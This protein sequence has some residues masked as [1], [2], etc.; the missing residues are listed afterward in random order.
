GFF[1]FGVFKTVKQIFQAPGGL[2]I[3]FF[4]HF[5]PFIGLVD[6]VSIQQS[7]CFP[8]LVVK[9]ILKKSYCHS[10]GLPLLLTLLT[11]R[12]LL[13]YKNFTQACIIISTGAN[14]DNDHPL[15]PTGLS[16]LRRYQG[17]VF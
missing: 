3:S 13:P 2:G 1:D 16:L 8:G 9:P 10:N 5:C 12:Y 14:D 17:Q 11:S 7:S 6:T 4:C 15:L